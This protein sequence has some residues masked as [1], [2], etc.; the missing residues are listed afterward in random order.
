MNIFKYIKDRKERAR[1]KKEFLH[2]LRG[3]KFESWKELE[4]YYKGHINFNL[5][6]KFDPNRHGNLYNTLR[7]LENSA[8]AFLKEWNGR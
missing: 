2:K 3:T 1:L 6:G 5:D 7:H 4:K 8:E